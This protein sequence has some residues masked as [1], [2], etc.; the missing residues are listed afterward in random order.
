MQYLECKSCTVSEASTLDVM[1]CE[2]Q[3][4]TVRGLTWKAV[5]ATLGCWGTESGLRITFL[6]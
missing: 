5:L 6:S 3:M 4:C 2:C 1:A